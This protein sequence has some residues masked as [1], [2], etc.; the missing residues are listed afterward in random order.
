MYR[1][2]DAVERQLRII[3]KQRHDRR[4]FYFDLFKKSPLMFAAIGLMGGIIIQNMF[5]FPLYVWIAVLGSTVMLSVACFAGFGRFAN[6]SYIPGRDAHATTVQAMGYLAAIAF[7]C[8]GAIRLTTYSIPANND[9]RVLIGDEKSLATLRG[10]ILSVPLQEDRSDWEFADFV[11]TDPSTSFYLNIAEIKCIDGW[12]KAVGTVRVQV[13]EPVLDLRAGDC[14]EAYC[15]LDQFKPV[16]NPGQFDVKT[17]LARKNVYVAAFIKTRSGIELIERPATRTWAAI[18]SKLKLKARQLLLGQTLV[19]NDEQAMLAALLLGQRNTVSPEIITAFYKTGLI[20]ILALSGGHVVA[21]IAIVWW[22]TKIAGLEKRRRAAVCLFFIILFTTVV[23]PDASVLRASIIGIFFCLSLMVR[24]SPNSLNTLSLSAIILILLRPL[25]FYQAGWQLSFACVLGILLLTGKI[26]NFIHHLTA[27]WFILDDDKSKWLIFLKRSGAVTIQ[28]FAAGIGATIGGAGILLYHFYTITP[29]T[30]VW[31]IL[32]SP[33]VTVIL[34]IGFLKIVL[35]ILLPTVG[36]AMSTLTIPLSKLF[37]Y[38][39]DAMARI[40]SSQLLIGAVPIYLILFYYAAIL[41]IA[42]VYFENRR[43]KTITNLTCIAVL[44]GAIGYYK[45]ERT[46]R[47]HL[48]LSVLSVGHGQAVVA[49]LPGTAT[50]MFDSG[51]LTSKDIGRRVVIPFLNYHG[52][53]TIDAIFISHSDIDHINGIAEIVRQRPVEHIYLDSGETMPKPAAFLEQCLKKAGKTFEPPP[54]IAATGATISVLWPTTATLRLGRATQ[55][56]NNFS[57]VVLLEYAG[58]KILLCSDIEK[59]TQQ[60]ILEL[61]PDLN[62]DVLL[63]PHHGSTKTRLPIF[64]EKLRPSVPLCS[65]T[66]SQFEKYQTAPAT[67]PNTLYTCRDGTITIAISQTGD[68]TV[69]SFLKS[70]TIKQSTQP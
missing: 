65:C 20:H 17:Y 33:L 36:A 16:Q 46:Y 35:G 18:L 44:V 55:N 7:A 43:L 23:P 50:I 63:L 15:W 6:R 40:D 4:H 62:V 11:F 22:F 38:I 30:I 41:F 54:S 1:N 60:K 45:F 66:Q 68:I 5:V 10:T 3:D 39:V 37:I 28:V 9:I 59:E 56:Q 47:E 34:T 8:L 58:R 67:D 26:E 57:Q 53:R 13:G 19:E 61:Y 70:P 21:L 42:F 25:E 32:V 29:L 49:R 31:T 69:R 24:Q 52:I 48:E 64:V 51:S 14:I 12:Q 27:D 2:L